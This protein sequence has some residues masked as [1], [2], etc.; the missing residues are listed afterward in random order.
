MNLFI[1]GHVW[2]NLR[3]RKYGHILGEPPYWDVFLLVLTL[4]KEPFHVYLTSMKFFY[5]SVVGGIQYISLF[6]KIN[7]FGFENANLCAP[8]CYELLP[9]HP[10]RAP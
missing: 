5:G 3:I 2:P 4:W 9:T 8:F 7:C 6:Y 10:K 1:V